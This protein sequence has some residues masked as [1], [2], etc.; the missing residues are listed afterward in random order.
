MLHVFLLQGIFARWSGVLVHETSVIARTLPAG[1]KDRSIETFDE[2]FVKETLL[3]GQLLSQVGSN[4]IGMKAWL[5]SF[6]E[7]SSLSSKFEA[8]VRWDFCYH[9]VSALLRFMLFRLCCELFCCRD[10]RQAL[11]KNVLGKAEET[12]DDTKAMVSTILGY[13]TMLVKMPAAT[14]KKQLIKDLCKKIKSRHCQ[15]PEKVMVRIN[16]A[17]GKEKKGQA[18]PLL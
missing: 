11:H 7:F 15:I 8:R 1:W 13:H 6:K 16:A 18:T 3:Q 2:Q 12:A 5:T 17:A 9:C 10:T 4:Y 14:D